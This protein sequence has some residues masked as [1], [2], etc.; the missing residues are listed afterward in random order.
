MRQGALIEASNSARTHRVST[1]FVPFLFELRA[2]KVKVGAQEAMA[3]ALPA[4]Y[5]VHCVTTLQDVA[6]PRTLPGGEP[7]MQASVLASQALYLAGKF[8]RS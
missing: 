8:L 6:V 3:L 1:S 7:W 5:L 2:R 4:F